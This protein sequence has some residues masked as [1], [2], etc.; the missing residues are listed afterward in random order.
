M[1][2]YDMIFCFYKSCTNTS[3]KRW[4]PVLQDDGHVRIF[5]TYVVACKTAKAYSSHNMPRSHRGGIQVQLY[6]LPSKLYEG[7][8][9]KPHPGRFSPRKKPHYPMNMTLG[10]SQGRP[11]RA[12]EDYS[13][14]HP[15]GFEPLT[16]Q[17]LSSRHTEYT[18]FIPRTKLLLSYNI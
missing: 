11:G 9:A 10:G 2:L 4:L 12:W 8:L 16:V 14:F 5:K 18:L 6:S 15:S 1:I 17:P 13:P 7:S 3:T